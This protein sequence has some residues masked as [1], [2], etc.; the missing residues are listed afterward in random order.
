[1]SSYQP[2]GYSTVSPVPQRGGCSSNDTISQACPAP[3]ALPS[4]Q[5]RPEE[6][7]RSIKIAEAG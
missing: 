6:E 1:M 5:I 3:S 4:F 2:V 7:N